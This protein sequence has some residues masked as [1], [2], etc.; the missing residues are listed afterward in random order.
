MALANHLRN[1][2]QAHGTV[3]SILSFLPSKTKSTFILCILFPFF[4]LSTPPFPRQFSSPKSPL[5][6]TSFLLFLVEKRQPAGLGFGDGSGRGCPT[7]KKG[8][9]FFWRARK[10]EKSHPSEHPEL[11]L[12]LKRQARESTW[13]T[14][15]LSARNVHSRRPYSS[16]LISGKSH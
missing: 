13:V 4:A 1:L 6:G 7:G 2:T 8:N 16:F 9:P 3:M 5:S 14:S 11:L 15:W 12:L 10:G